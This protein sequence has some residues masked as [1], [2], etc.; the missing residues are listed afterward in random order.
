MFFLF[1]SPFLSLFYFLPFLETSKKRPKKYKR[2]FETS[3]TKEDIGASII[4]IHSWA[5]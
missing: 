4:N 1:R 3:M 2:Y 5:R